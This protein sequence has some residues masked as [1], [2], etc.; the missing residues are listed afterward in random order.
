MVLTLNSKDN[1]TINQISKIVNN[2]MDIFLAGIEGNEPFSSRKKEL[3][4]MDID[5]PIKNFKQ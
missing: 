2:K 1:N 3:D 4:D 5:I